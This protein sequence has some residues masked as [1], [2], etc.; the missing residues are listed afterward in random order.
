MSLPLA[1]SLGMLYPALP[2]AVSYVGST[3]IAF[4]TAG[5]LNAATNKV[6]FMGNV[7]INGR[8]TSKVLSS[9]GGKIDWL[10]GAVTWAT[11]NSAIQVGIQ[12]VSTAAGPVQP[13]G[14]FDVSGT[15]VQGTDTIT[16]STWKSTTMGTGSKTIAH[17][18]FIAIVLDMTVRNGADSV[19]VNG[20]TG[21]NSLRPCGN[22]YTSSAW[23]TPTASSFSPLAM[24]TFDDGTLGWIDG[25]LPASAIANTT[26]TDGSATDEYGMLFQVPWDC[27][28][29][30]IGGCFCLVGDTSEAT[31]TLYS[32]PTGTPAAISGAQL[33]LLGEQ[34]ISATNA[35]NSVYLLPSIVRLTRNTNYVL[36]LKAT[37]AGNILMLFMTLA[38]AAFRAAL[39]G[40]TTLAQATRNAG[41]GAF[42][43]T[44]TTTVGFMFV[45]IAAVAGY[46]GFG[47]G[48]VANA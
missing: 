17:G 44:A 21:I 11:A 47:I 39:S 42:T 30:A 27:D 26:Y 40:G 38:D 5:T 45:R 29:D 18:D 41:S 7:F 23:G 2:H 33:N 46:Q 6:A 25:T 16:A 13:D 36:A 48:S 28:I 12:D 34:R 35:R 20:L 8:A 22:V 15:L 43:V 3:G 1:P 37:G 14:S 4:V 24:I 9:A 32:T 31:L 10:P 19:V